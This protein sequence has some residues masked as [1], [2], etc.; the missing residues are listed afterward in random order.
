MCKCFLC[1]SSRAPTKPRVLPAG[2]A[3]ALNCRHRLVV[4]CFP[5]SPPCSSSPPLIHNHVVVVVAAIIT[6]SGEQPTA[7]AASPSRHFSRHVRFLRRPVR[8]AAPRVRLISCGIEQVGQNQRRTVVRATRD[9]RTDIVRC[10]GRAHA[11]QTVAR[12][13][14]QHR[15]DGVRLGCNM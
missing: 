9:A 10:A 6:I 3:C 13:L 15:S 8:C 5:F 12:L 1:T 11:L 7:A 2:F 4:S 14:R